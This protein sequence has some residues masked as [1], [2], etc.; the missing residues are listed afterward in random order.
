MALSGF[1]FFGPD[2]GGFAGPQPGEELF[3]RW[4]QVGLFLPRFT[5]HSWKPGAASTMPWLYPA[6]MPTVRRLFD[7]REPLVPHL[8]EAA[9]NARKE[10]LPLIRPV[11]PEDPTYDEES[12]CFLCGRR[13]LAC[14]VF[15]EGAESVTVTLP[16]F[17]SW[18]LRGEGELHPPG[19]T[20]TVPCRPTDL[21]VW[22]VRED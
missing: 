12:D 11:F 8:H 6:L 20:L 14:P 1:L 5:L 21:P 22:F 9:E 3:L 16:R 7:L 15:D 18:R 2:I 13:I 10:R 17:G 4:L 19:E